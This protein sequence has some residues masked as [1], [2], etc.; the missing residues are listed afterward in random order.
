[1]LGNE[2]KIEDEKHF[3]LSCSYYADFCSHLF[4]DIVLETRFINMSDRNKLK[5]LLRTFPRKCT[6]YITQAYM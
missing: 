6:K 1:M 2:N 5:H 3:I 4:E